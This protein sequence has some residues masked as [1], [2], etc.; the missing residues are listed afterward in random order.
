M[1]ASILLKALGLNTAINQLETPPGSMIEAKNIIIRDENVIEP[2]RGMK[3][4]GETFGTSSD[5]AKQL[6]SYRDRII[7]HYSDKLEFDA[8]TQTTSGVEVFNEFS[9]SYTETEP[10]L[11]IKSIEANGNLYFT[12]NDGIKKISAKNASQLTTDS[13]Y[14]VD[15]GGIKAVDLT[16]EI[17]YELGDQTSFLP[18]DSAVAYRILWLKRDNNNN[19]I[20][21]TPSQRSEIYNS[22]LALEL[23][24]FNFILGALDDINQTGSLIT[25]GD[26]VETLKLPITASASE[27]RTNLIALAAK[28]D[29]DI[30]YADETTPGSYPLDIST[31]SVTSNVVTITFS[32]GDPTDY[33]IIGSKIEISGFS[34]SA[35]NSLDGT[36]SLSAVTATTISFNKTAPDG[37]GTVSGSAFIR[38]NEYRS[39]TQPSIPSTPTTNAQL[40]EIQTYLQSIITRLQSEPEDVISNSLASQYI[41][42][43]DITTT[44]H[45]KLN[46]TIPQN[47]TSNDFFQVYRSDIA[48]A[49]GTTVLSD[50]VPD[51]E[52]KLVYE[53]FPTTAELA[54]KEIIIE[55][56]TPDEFRGANLYTNEA[57]GEGI[58]QANDIPPLAKDI[59]TFKNYTFYAN[60]Q[61]RHRKQLSLLGVTNMVL[62][63]G[64]GLNSNTFTS[65][66]VNTTTDVIT[67]TAHGY[68]DGQSVEFSNAIPSNL[69]GG[70]TQSV[71]YYILNAT[72]NT[73]QISLEK[74]GSPVDITSGG[75]GTHTVKNQL[76]QIVITN[77]TTTNVY[78]FVVGTYE[79]TQFTTIAGSLLNLVGEGSYF[80][81]NSANDG[82]LYTPW[83]SNG[84]TTDPN[85]PGRISIP[86]VF[87]GSETDAQIAE[88]SANKLST[89]I[90]DFSVVSSTNTF[91]VTNILSG[92]T[93]DATAETSGFTVSVLTQGIGEDASQNQVLLSNLVSVGQAVDETA[94]SLVRVINKNSS[95]IVAAYYLS[96]AGGVP[97]QILLESLDLS[98]GIVYILG[99][100]DNTGLSFNPDIGPENYIVS[101]SV[102]NPTV[103][104]SA[105]PHGMENGDQV[106]II[107]SNSTPSIDGLY[108]ITYVTSTTFS[109]PV[110]VTVAGTMGSFVIASNAVFSDN[111]EKPN[112]IYYSKFQEPEAVPIVNFL[113][114]GSQDKE[115]LRIFPLR[116]SLFVFKE[117]G[118]Y[119]ISG[120]IAPFVTALFDSSCI[121]I[122]PDSLAVV[123]NV[124]Y[125][126]T[127]HGISIITESGTDVITKNLDDI[128]LRLGSDNYPDFKTA[129]WGVGYEA[130]N[131]Y[132]VYTVKT[133]T[134][135]DAEIGYRYDQITRTWTSIDKDYRCG[136]INSDGRLYAGP[137]DTNA[138]EQERKQFNRYDYAD[139]EISNELA[140]NSYFD[141][142]LKFF[143]VDD[144]FEGDVL[145]QNQLL[146]IYQYNQ[147]LKKLDTDTSVNDTDYFSTLEAIGGVSLRTKIIELAQ[148]LDADTGI[149]DSNYFDNI[150]TKSG[151][152][153]A[154]S[155]SNPTIITTSTPHELHTGRI[156]TISGTNSNPPINDTYPVTVISPTTF[157]VPVN[158]NLTAGTTGSFST[159]DT[160]FRD[161][162]T[163]YNVIIEKLNLDVGVN[164]SNYQ[165]SVGTT[166][167]ESVITRVNKITKELTVNLTLPYIQ[168]PM[169]IFNSIKT[170]F[171]YS[172][173]TFDDPLSL[174]QVREFTMMFKDK[175]FTSATISFASDLKPKFNR[176]P[177]SGDGNGIFGFMNFGE[178]FFG[179]GSHAAPFR[180]YIP[181]DNVRCRYI[182]VKFEHGI[183]REFY[184][185]YGITL[186]AE[187]GQSS[188][189]YR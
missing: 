141:T 105:S 1:P 31:V 48:Q 14:I 13:G 101:N 58:T 65:V 95:E 78:K 109:I 51:D 87:D 160:D 71:T 38:S 63:Y 61:T 167:Q 86:I 154:V 188:R 132:I 79:Q 130:D 54:A 59:N 96:T 103:I 17:V 52:M 127:T 84:V 145:V 74:D 122:P 94:R 166:V 97:G 179:G 124:I 181:R 183:A 176:V 3:I 9:G 36:Y 72:A 177:F 111:E 45:T 5:R 131:S 169:I 153:T 143:Q 66:D 157:S 67:N 83:Y 20:R 134:D 69:P 25:D 155:I 146:T 22:L 26:Y 148:K 136:V 88:K 114:V 128:F 102:A 64:S 100:N 187:T 185:I 68:L 175:S 139:R 24:D 89:F 135:E 147:T 85:I 121:L 125:G 112:R 44:V 120:E 57:T 39:I 62:D 19:L 82:K 170:S 46:I 172:P 138:I 55:D 80:F 142:L 15:A 171:I 93:T 32:T 107:N 165:P 144:T 8:G 163:C 76:P 113:D 126:W 27:L 37:A 186:V 118:L 140:P 42:V 2:R 81:L 75:T 180:S 70:I 41:D 161:I 152:I 53:A 173:S 50:L 178:G 129:T 23:Q 110:N 77:G 98:S 73:F 164:F 29:F 117:D 137:G 28:L 182:V 123:N 33:F 10:G 168:G 34:D 35:T 6:I 92:Y 149:A 115:I 99:N 119:R 49:T 40:V 21:G 7:R 184:K 18:Q 16:S 189:A 43:L 151:T 162:Q 90:A 11:R 108:S 56:I 4:F 133:T 158:V 156:V 91:T 30:K 159:I 60:T 12:T 116:D 104:T 106:V 174:K 150:D 47:V